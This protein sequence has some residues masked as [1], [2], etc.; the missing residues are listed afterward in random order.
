MRPTTPEVGVQLS[1]E[2]QENKAMR[3]LVL[4]TP[5]LAC[6]REPQHQCTSALV[7]PLWF[8]L[9]SFMVMDSQH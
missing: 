9:L 5:R 6:I 4:E 1:A 3:G 8:C 2:G 7:L